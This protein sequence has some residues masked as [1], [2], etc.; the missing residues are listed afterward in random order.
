MGQKVLVALISEG[1]EFQKLQADD[2]RL[3]GKRAGLEIEVRH[4]GHDPAVQLRQV[5]EALD[6]PEP[7]RPVGIIVEPAAAVGLDAAAR[8]AAEAGVGWVLL[9]DRDL[10][11]KSIRK[12]FPG[13][14]LVQVATDNDGIGKLQAQ[15]FRALLPRGGSLLCVEG[16]SFSA[17]ALHRREGMHKALTGSGIEVLKELSGD[18]TQASAEKAV[19][20]WVKLWSRGRRPDVVGAQ[21]DEMAMGARKA[22]MALRPD[23]KDVR[24]V[25]VDGLPEGGQRMV[26]EGQLVATVIT[27]PPTGRGVELIAA[28]LRGEEVPEVTLMPPQP[29][30]PPGEL[31]VRA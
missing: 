19:T 20:I 29:F 25:G 27:P 10:S 6:A 2:A 5:N 17:A 4:A 21:N 1:Q 22:L 7:Q 14:L 3:A 9:G 26:R 30:P 31:L 23:W 16:P 11:L 13:R 24:F 15:L 28:A 18:W 12:Q 8:R